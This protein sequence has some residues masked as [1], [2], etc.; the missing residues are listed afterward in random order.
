MKDAG[1]CADFKTSVS[2]GY[3]WAAEEMKNNGCK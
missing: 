1:A 3:T 2:L